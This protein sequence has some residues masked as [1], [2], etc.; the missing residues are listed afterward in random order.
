MTGSNKMACTLSSAL[1]VW[2]LIL[3]FIFEIFLNF[4][5]FSLDT[6]IKYILIE[7][8]PYKQTNKQKSLLKKVREAHI[9]QNQ[10]P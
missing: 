9:K 1:K 5:N 7:K 4:A 8:Q 10:A 6:L 2:V 3:R